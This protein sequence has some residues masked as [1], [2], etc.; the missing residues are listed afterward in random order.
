YARLTAVS[1]RSRAGSSARPHGSRITAR[2]I[3]ARRSAQREHYMRWSALVYAGA[4]VA[5]GW[6]PASGQVFHSSAGD[7]VVQTA[8]KGLDHPWALAFLPDGRMLVT[9]RPGR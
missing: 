8:A 6:V 7:F 9:E 3:D 5:A 2:R 4:L 1:R